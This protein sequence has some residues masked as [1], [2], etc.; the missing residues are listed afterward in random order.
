M[1][2]VMVAFSAALLVAISLGLWGCGDEDP[3]DPPAENCSISITSPLAGTSFMPGDADHQELNIRWNKTGE[4]DLVK[5]DLLKGGELVGNIHQSSPNDGFFSWTANNLGA[6]NGSDFSVR[7]TAQGDD[8]CSDV[9]GLFTMT[10]I[11]DCAF[12]FTHEF[13]DSLVAGEVFNL[14]WDSNNTSGNV[15]IQLRKQDRSLGFIATGIQD[16]GS[17]AWN[18]DSLHNGSY[19]YYFL[20]IMDSDVENCQVDGVEF[21]MIDEDICYIDVSVPQADAVWTEGEVRSINITGAAEVATVDLRLYMG[22][23][24]LGSIANNV[25]M[26][27]FPLSWSVMDFGNIQANTAYKI[28]AT[29]IDDEYCTGE[30]GTFTIISR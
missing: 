9:S 19:H 14:T 10:S 2:K 26:D 27:D 24:Y 3:V 29:S 1:S 30:S 16:T 18:I 23:I 21:W 4:A 20:R 17:F 11:I 15:D 13:R 6:T 12:D 28:V 22:N 7:V 25:S 8:G 5:I